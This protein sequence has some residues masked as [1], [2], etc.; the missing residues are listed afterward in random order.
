MARWLGYV[1]VRVWRRM[2]NAPKG[3]AQ[4]K[5]RQAASPCCPLPVR[6]AL[7]RARCRGGHRDSFSR[8][9]CLSSIPS[10]APLP[11]PLGLTQTH[12]AN[13]TQKSTQPSWSSSSALC[14]PPNRHQAPKYERKKNPRPEK[15][16]A[17]AVSLCSGCGPPVGVRPGAAAA[18][19]TTGQPA[20]TE[21]GT[22]WG[23]AQTT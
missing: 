12:D 11:V 8:L 20:P 10:G 7:S 15:T 19:P 6:A 3:Y 17:I 4:P 18:G 9:K 13:V 21:F 5:A 14:S 2:G 23:P 16:H 22:V 1:Q